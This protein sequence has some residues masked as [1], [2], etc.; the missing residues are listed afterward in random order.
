MWIGR[1]GEQLEQ[2]ILRSFHV[3]EAC[4]GVILKPFSPLPGS[5]EFKSNDAYLADVPMAHLSPHCFPFAE[6]NG[7]TRS[8]YHDLYRMAAFLND[9]VRNHAF[10]FLKGTLGA[11]MLRDS[12]AREVWRL[13]PTPVRPAD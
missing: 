10:D 3:V 2:T 5:A 11:A 6:L 7:I 4:G 9:R 12:L 1:P 13:E 8:E